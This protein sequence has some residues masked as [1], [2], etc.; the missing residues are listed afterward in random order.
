MLSAALNMRT[1]YRPSCR[2]K[3]RIYTILRNNRCCAAPSLTFEQ[4]IRTFVNQLFEVGEEAFK[5]KSLDKQLEQ[6]NSLDKVDTHTM[7]TATVAIDWVTWF[8]G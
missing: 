7:H 5:N 6:G 1:L 8:R 4:L 3:V 2:S